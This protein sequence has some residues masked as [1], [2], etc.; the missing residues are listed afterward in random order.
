MQ[1]GDKVVKN[2]NTWIASEFDAWGR[3]EGVGEIVQP[4]FD[5]GGD[6]LD[7]RWPA[8]RCFEHASGLSPVS[9]DRSSL[10]PNP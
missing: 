9:N 10:T 4:P 3:G 1:I 5:L 6:W 8:G 2:P 7:V